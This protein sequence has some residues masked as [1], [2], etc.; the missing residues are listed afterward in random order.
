MKKL[1]NSLLAQYLLIIL[2]ATMIMPI[3]V[4][5]LSIVFYNITHQ[6][7]SSGRHYNGTDLEEMW[8]E[9]AKELGDASEE[10]IH[11]KLTELKNIYQE[12]SMYR[13]DK[14]GQTRE[15]SPKSLSVPDTWSVPYAIDF[16]KKNRGYKIDPFTVVAFI[17]NKQEEG[18]MVL[19]IPRTDMVSPS[20]LLLEQ[21]DYI[22]PFALLSI[23][24]LFMLISSLFFYRI[25]KRLLH[26]QEAMVAPEANGIPSTIEVTKQDEIGRLGQSFNRM[27]QELETGRKREKEEEGLR[28]ELIAN[29]SHDLRTP[30]TTIRGHAYRLKKEPLSVTGQE[31]LD[32]IDEKVN[33]MGELIENL[34]SYT[35]LTTGKYPFHPEKVDIIR[36][37]RT[38]FAEWYPVFENLHFDIQL[39]IPEKQL[40]WEV[41]PQMFRRVLDN[42]FQNIYRHAKSGQFVAVRIEN[43]TIVIEDHGPGMKAKSSKK[44]VGVGLSV[45]SL[46]LKEMQLDWDIETSE[47]GTM[48]IIQQA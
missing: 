7:D 35:L 10:Q 41:D 4:P 27:I 5:L 43:E 39:E 8:H 21:Y 37:I 3:G 46:M 12:A 13:V 28:K 6:E 36:L 14:A 26:L 15:K 16:M 20:N 22:F 11:S 42:L 2:L 24:V 1:G 40:M 33:Y 30:L 25:R 44:G 32:F 48:M 18:F 17:G 47:E 38:S 34:L 23:F 29:L 45:V 31:S 19:Q 9:T